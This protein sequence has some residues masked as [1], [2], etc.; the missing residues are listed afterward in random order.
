MDE[1]ML[2]MRLRELEFLCVRMGARLA[3]LEAHVLVQRRADP[4]KDC[5]APLPTVPLSPG[6]VVLPAEWDEHVRR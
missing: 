3:A 1:R 4:S 5:S 2:E 6:R